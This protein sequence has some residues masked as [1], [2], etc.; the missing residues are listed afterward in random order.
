MFGSGK[1]P[2]EGVHMN[3][4][5]GEADSR[6]PRTPFPEDNYSNLLSPFSH[7]PGRRAASSPKEKAEVLRL[8]EAH[9]TSECWE[10][11]AKPRPRNNE[12]ADGGPSAGMWTL[13]LPHLTNLGQLAV[14]LKTTFKWHSASLFKMWPRDQLH[15]HHSG[16]C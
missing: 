4:S 6:A 1:H 12:G 10:P 8:G 3:D 5:N 13:P 16:T 9:G 11:V 14:G 7:R 15:G 2:T